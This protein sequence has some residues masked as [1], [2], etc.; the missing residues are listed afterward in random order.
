MRV[1]RAAQQPEDARPSWR[2]SRRRRRRG[3]QEAQHQ[4]VLHCQAAST[5]VGLRVRRQLRTASIRLRPPDVDRPWGQ[6]K[7]SGKGRR[8]EA[9]AH[10]DDDEGA[11]H[12]ASVLERS[13]A[14][15]VRHGEAMRLPAAILHP[16]AVRA[17]LPLQQ[18]LGGRVEEACCAPAHVC[19]PSRPST[20]AT[21]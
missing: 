8:R 9:G 19:Q 17:Q 2:E 4:A 16:G 20:S 6:E 12:V 3:G 13:P 15:A 7:P 21:P 5:A 18:I 14:R 1:V 10:E 11:P